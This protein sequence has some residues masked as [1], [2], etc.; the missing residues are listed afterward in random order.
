M[1]N[2][3]ILTIILIESY[4]LVQYRIELSIRSIGTG[5]G[6]NIGIY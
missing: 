4:C 2:D 5:S 3:Q 1:G 6:L